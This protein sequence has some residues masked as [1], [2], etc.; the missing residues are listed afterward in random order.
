MPSWNRSRKWNQ[1][2]AHTQGVYYL[3]IALAHIFRFI[4][5][6]ID[7]WVFNSIVLLLPRIFALSLWLSNA[8]HTYPCAAV[9]YAIFISRT[10]IDGNV[11]DFYVVKCSQLLSFFLSIWSVYTAACMDWVR[12]AIGLAAQSFLNLICIHLHRVKYSSISFAK[13]CVYCCCDGG[14]MCYIKGTS[15]LFLSSVPAWRTMKKHLKRQ[16]VANIGVQPVLLEWNCAD[17]HIVQLQCSTVAH[18]AFHLYAASN[19]IATYSH[20]TRD[21][22]ISALF[23]CYGMVRRTECRQCA[24]KWTALYCVH[25]YVLFVCLFAGWNFFCRSMS[26]HQKL[27][28]V[29]KTKK[30]NSNTHYTQSRRE[31]VRRQ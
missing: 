22:E 6:L 7:C 8:A 18:A 13:W 1:I 11:F 19:T 24:P 28:Y 14:S 15:L 25:T 9:C 29:R 2:W 30:D 3:D 21:Q 5:N 12:D 20:K 10:R 27:I 17:M 4:G 26:W 23:R 16:N 31:R